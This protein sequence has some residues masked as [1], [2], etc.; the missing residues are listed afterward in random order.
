MRGLAVVAVLLAPMIVVLAAIAEL[1]LIAAAILGIWKL[2]RWTLAT[3][4][5]RRRQP[6]SRAARLDLEIDRLVS[7]APRERQAA[8]RAAY[9][10]AADMKLSGKGHTPAYAAALA[11][12]DRLA[13]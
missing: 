4:P 7:R 12:I 1:A 10:A 8:M 9:E 11:A 13:R 2:V 6:L 5:H 3:W